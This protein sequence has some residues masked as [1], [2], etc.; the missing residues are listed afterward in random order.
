MT[1][2]SDTIEIVKQRGL[3]A[4]IADGI[5]G[6]VRAGY[7]FSDTGLEIENGELVIIK[8]EQLSN[9][10]IE[11]IECL[12]FRPEEGL[13]VNGM[14]TSTSGTIG[15]FTITD[16][17]IQSGNVTITSQVTD[18]DGNIVSD[19]S[20][21]V[22]NLKIGNGA[23]ITDYLKLGNFFLNKPKNSNNSVFYLVEEETENKIVTLSN[24]GILTLGRL[25]SENKIILDGNDS[26]IKG[27]NWMIKPDLA[28]FNNIS[29]S[30][31]I[32]TAIFEKGTI[33]SVGSTMVFSKN[34]YIRKGNINYSVNNSEFSFFVN[35][36]SM[37]EVKSSFIEG[38]YIEFL[39][40][41]KLL[42]AV[43]N[44]V[45]NGQITAT[46]LNNGSA[47]AILSAIQDEKTIVSIL[48]NTTV[49][50]ISSD[51]FPP[52]YAAT[53]ALTLS[54]IQNDKGFLKYDKSLILGKLDGL[55][56]KGTEIK[57]KF[58]LYCQDVYLSGQ[59][60]GSYEQ[61]EDNELKEVYFAGINTNEEKFSSKFNNEPIILWAGATLNSDDIPFYV[62]TKG[63]L[64][65]SQG[66]FSGSIIT[67]SYIEAA[68]IK[69]AAIYP[70]DRKEGQ[71]GAVPA[72]KIY[73]AAKDDNSSG[74]SFMSKDEL[75]EKEILNLSTK[76]FVL[77]ESNSFISFDESKVTFSGSFQ[78]DTGA[79]FKDNSFSLI[80]KN[81]SASFDFISKEELIVGMTFSLNEA[82]K[83]EVLSEETKIF[84]TEEVTE[85]LIL[86]NMRYTKVEKGY[87]LFVE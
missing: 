5:K 48:G 73:N 22:T 42:Y 19:S 34:Y 23:E 84:G 2:K 72:L 11:E 87:D 50:S 75:E 52:N 71:I 79:F 13:K 57:E 83:I 35:T 65:A 77:E 36:N 41:K 32:N 29:I 85:N 62:T 7:T 3:P 51:S 80:K 55:N 30:G 44:R 14:I 6:A 56:Y 9:D 70:P 26:I 37:D 12:S 18:Q 27:N 68:S 10:K 66:F 17:T 24:K 54:K 60:V 8:K 74:I 76:G 1:L 28:T 43:V 69:A 4:I 64:Y 59:M 33:Q 81:G 53:Y 45:E 20:I 46:I 38:Y 15:G 47:A 86:G 49:M 16:K 67:N 31:S 63:N 82:S 40:D 25:E 21:E 39:Y 61:Y 58:G 78:T